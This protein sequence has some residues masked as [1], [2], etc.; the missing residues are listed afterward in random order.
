MPVGRVADEPGV[1]WG[2]IMN[3]LSMH[4]P[5]PAIQT[6][7]PTRGIG[8]R[9]RLD[10]ID[11]LRGVVMVLMAL[12]HVRAFFTNPFINPLDLNNPDVPLFLTRWVTHYCAP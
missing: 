6:G 8:V 2:L 9:P 4:A 10:A 7:M 11:Q 5:A 1:S 3:Q 12:D